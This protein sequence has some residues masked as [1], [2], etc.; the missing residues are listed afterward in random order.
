MQKVAAFVFLAVL[1]IGAASSLAVG[2]RILAGIDT[3]VVMAV[4]G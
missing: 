4:A 3:P 2:T 1:A